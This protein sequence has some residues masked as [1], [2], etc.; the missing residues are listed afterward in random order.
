MAKNPQ[1]RKWLITINNPIEKG[2][3]IAHNIL[4]Y[5]INLV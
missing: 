1:A 5:N 4:V 3:I 2:Y